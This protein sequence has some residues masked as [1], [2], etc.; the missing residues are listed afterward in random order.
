MSWLG[1]MPY[2]FKETLFRLYDAYSERYDFYSLLGVSLNSKLM[3]PEYPKYADGMKYYMRDF[4]EAITVLL[5]RSLDTRKLGDWQIEDPFGDFSSYELSMW[6][7]LGVDGKAF[8]C[9]DV[10]MPISDCRIVEAWYKVLNDYIRYPRL[11]IN[12]LAVAEVS[13]GAISYR[14]TVTVTDWS[15][16]SRYGGSRT[17]P[18]EANENLPVD[19]GYLAYFS[20]DDF[21]QGTS[22]TNVV[23]DTL[24]VTTGNWEIMGRRGTAT[25]RWS[26]SVVNTWQGGNFII[27]M[28]GASGSI[29]YPSDIAEV[30]NRILN[31][32]RDNNDPSSASLNCIFRFGNTETRELYKVSAENLPD[33][34]YKY[35]DS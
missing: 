27:A 29:S 2:P 35:L 5:R 13:V 25:E 4:A 16:D 22:I 28:N 34:Q 33:P 31:Y 19:R 6:D 9:K 12:M 26:N 7:A 17:V 10:P 24:Y 14:G 8:F 21:R 15:E 30:R 1:K 20:S 32:P 3:P 23:N 18:Y 11:P